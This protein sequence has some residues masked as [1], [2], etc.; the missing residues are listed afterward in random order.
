MYEFLTFDCYGTLIDWENGISEAISV[1]ARSAGVKVRR[2]EIMQAYL[3]VEPTIQATEYRSY[4]EIL[5]EAAA[6]TAKLLGWTV[7][8]EHAGFLAESL[9][10]WK[11]FA[12]TNG[13]LE[14]LK[15]DGY[16]LGISSNID[17]D[18][19]AGT[20]RHFSVDFDM[21]VTAQSVRSYKPA[22]AH[23]LKA[24][25]SLSGTAWLHAAQSFFHDV[26]PACALDI[27]VVWVNRSREAPAGSACPTGEVT[28]LVEL[29]EWLRSDRARSE[30]GD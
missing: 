15:E 1:A 28:T 18:L 10:T 17:D 11:P 23:F 7:D 19:L 9:P 3:Q 16:R 26:S 12:D 22:H 20:L 24:R 21:L 4:R 8:P 29:V 5:G 30:A 27:P 6:R 25:E 2:D 13:A 14:Q